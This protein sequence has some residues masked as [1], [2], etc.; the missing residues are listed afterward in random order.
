MFLTEKIRPSKENWKIT[1]D[2]KN[3]INFIHG[4]AEHGDIM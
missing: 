1:R 2:E 3:V 4:L